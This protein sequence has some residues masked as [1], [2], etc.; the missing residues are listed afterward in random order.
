MHGLSTKEITIISW[1]SLYVACRG[2]WTF[3]E[4]WFLCTMW[5][6]GKFQTLKS[7]LWPAALNSVAEGA[8]STQG[9]ERV[10][11]EP[12]VWVHMLGQLKLSKKWEM[13]GKCK[14]LFYPT[15]SQMTSDT[16]RFLSCGSFQTALTDFSWQW[17]CRVLSSLFWF[18]FQETKRLKWLK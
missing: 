4:Y 12:T 6:N 11:E 1:H 3:I 15:W 5:I 13:A 16:R 18:Y 7:L 14:T 2:T 8:S 10:T 9:S 17:C